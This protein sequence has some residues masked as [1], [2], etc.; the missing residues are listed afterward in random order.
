M[1]SCC[2][3]S[4]PP[5]RMVRV[6][7]HATPEGS[8]AQLESTIL[9]FCRESILCIRVVLNF[10]VL[11]NAPLIRSRLVQHS[12]TVLY[13]TLNGR[14]MG[15]RPNR[16]ADSYSVDQ[17]HGG[18]AEN[19]CILKLHSVCAGCAYPYAV[20]RSTDLLRPPKITFWEFAAGRILNVNADSDCSS[21]IDRSSVP[22]ENS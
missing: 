18:T 10:C 5:S 8:G 22:V 11:S 16:P 3:N 1:A 4:P 9:F 13:I 17:A 12:T 6:L 19:C 2:P 15:L 7:V 20:Y 21:E 14:P